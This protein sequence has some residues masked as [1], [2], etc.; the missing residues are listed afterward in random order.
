MS[1]LPVDE[2]AS[3]LPRRKRKSVGFADREEVI[4]P[5]DVDASVGRF[6]NMISVEVIPSKVSNPPLIPL[7]TL[8]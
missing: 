5:E 1:A 8:L 3:K 4:N 6:R 2:P 7:H